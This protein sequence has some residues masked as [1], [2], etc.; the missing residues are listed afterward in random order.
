VPNVRDQDNLLRKNEGEINF[1]R[2]RQI[3]EVDFV[4]STPET[5]LP[6]EVKYQNHIRP[7]DLE[8]ML[9]YCGKEHL[10]KAMVVTKNEQDT[11]HI[12]GVKISFIPALTLL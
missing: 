7:G 1:W 3:K 6:I 8:S 12:N 2:Q 5:K 9:Y 4:Y 10:K 11:K